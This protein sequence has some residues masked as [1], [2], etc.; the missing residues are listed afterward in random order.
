[1][2]VGMETVSYLVANFPYMEDYV[3]DNNISQ[4]NGKKHVLIAVRKGSPLCDPARNRL[5][6]QII[7]F[8]ILR[9]SG[10]RLVCPYPLNRFP[11]FG[12]NPPDGKSLSL[13]HASA[14]IPSDLHRCSYPLFYQISSIDST[15]RW[16]PLLFSYTFP[17]TG[18]IRDFNPLE[19][20]AARRTKRTAQLSDI[21][22]EAALFV[23]L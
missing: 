2:I 9:V 4:A 7:W 14:S 15:S 16:T 12:I 23:G 3:S 13:N 18:W 8:I 10:F 20:C 21:F 22:P 5:V 1:M 19:T 17:T 11:I 6:L